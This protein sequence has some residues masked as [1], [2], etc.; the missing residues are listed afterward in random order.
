MNWHSLVHYQTT[1]SVDWL[2]DT[3]TKLSLHWNVTYRQDCWSHA[4]IGNHWCNILCLTQTY[5][6][7]HLSQH[8]GETHFKWLWVVPQALLDNTCTHQTWCSTHKLKPYSYSKH[9]KEKFRCKTCCC[10]YIP[11]VFRHMQSVVCWD[12][13]SF[14]I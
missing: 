10:K 1:L 9:H 2:C 12:V 8:L 7:T 14:M 3:C 6:I 5:D 11:V 13:E 4:R